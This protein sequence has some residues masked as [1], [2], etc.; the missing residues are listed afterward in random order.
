MNYFTVNK[1]GL[2]RQ[3]SPKP[4]GLDLA[5]TFEAITNWVR[6]KPLS[7]TLPWNANARS[8]KP[9]CYCKDIYT[10]EITGD[11]LVVLWK[12]ESSGSGNLLGA[13]E[14]AKTGEGNVVTQDAKFK[15]KKV[16]W[17][18]PMYYW[19][20][21]SEELVVSIK[22]ENSVCDSQLFQDWI[23]EAVTNRVDHGNKKKEY[24]A[25]GQTRLS[26]ADGTVGG[27]FR[28]RYL[29][30]VSLKTENTANAAM[31]ALASNITHVI[32]RETIT[33]KTADERAMWVKLFNTFPHLKP[34]PNSKTREIEIKAQARP[35]AAEVKKIIEG[36][37]RENRSPAE[38]DNVGFLTSDNKTIWVDRYRL[39][40]SIAYDIPKDQI[41]TAV[42]LCEA[43][44]KKRTN[45]LAPQIG[46]HAIVATTRTGT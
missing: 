22:F 9:K 10:S 26:F 17:G 30:D 5:E 6:G 7:D 21:P 39:T 12:S 11:I 44:A 4:Q 1:C 29:F 31:T 42:D 32:K 43:I 24:T 2:Y 16:I 45:F 28:Y 8:G 14:D 46:G 20:V 36:Y 19:I 41:V 37:A 33:L 15:G 35:T 13:P 34:A 27:D 40:N 25:S 38:W 3:T 23:T 18:H